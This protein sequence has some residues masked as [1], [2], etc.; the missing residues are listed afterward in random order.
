MASKRKPAGRGPV[1]AASRTSGS[2]VSG[3][4][5]VAPKF[6]LFGGGFLTLNLGGRGG[7]RGRK[8]LL[9]RMVGFLSLGARHLT[10]KGA[11]AGSGNGSGR[12]FDQFRADRPDL[13]GGEPGE[14][15]GVDLDENQGDDDGGPVGVPDHDGQPGGPTTTAHCPSCGHPP[16]GHSYSCQYRG[17]L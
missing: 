16:G 17:Y 8:G 7:G 2:R 3:S 14:A 13:F 4:V 11:K 10:G 1:R 6:T 5:S 15:A 12:T 9:S